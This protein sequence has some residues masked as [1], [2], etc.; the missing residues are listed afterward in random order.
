MR[1]AACTCLEVQRTCL[2]VRP[3]SQNRRLQQA[4][5]AAAG[6]QRTRSARRPCQGP[7][8]PSRRSK[9]SSRRP[10][11][12]HTAHHP[13][14]GLAPRIGWACTCVHRM[15][16]RAPLSSA[17]VASLGGGPG[18]R[19]SKPWGRAGQILPSWAGWPATMKRI[20]AHGVHGVCES[21]FC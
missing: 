15:H 7:R 11:Q 2:E 6:K 5:M 14:V 17:E 1:F 8:P 18:T 9:T 12:Q 13:Q 3:S 16:G 21:G 10:A 20:H 19:A 4:M